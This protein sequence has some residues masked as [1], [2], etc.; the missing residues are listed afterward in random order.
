VGMYTELVLGVALLDN[1]SDSRLSV[2]RGMVAGAD[3]IT[4]DRDHELFRTERWRWMLTSSSHYFVPE[5]SS[6]LVTND[7]CT[8]KHLS[9]RCDL[10]N[11]NGEIAAFLDWLAPSA[12]EGF[13]G[14]FRYEED[15]DPC[16][17][18]FF[19][20]KVELVQARHTP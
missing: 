19:G 2:I 3:E 18:Y 11:Y 16:L 4:P 10:K 5:A 6:K 1:I 9:V 17:V 13:A 20:G 15:A 8:S 12:Y 7:Y 14:Y